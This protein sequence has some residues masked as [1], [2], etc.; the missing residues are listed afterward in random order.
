MNVIFIRHADLKYP[1][2]NYDKLSLSNLDFLA[3]EKIQPHIN[4]RLAKSKIK[5]HLADGFLTKD[6]VDAIYFSSALRAKETAALLADALNVKE[7]KELKYLKEIA[8]SP[9]ELVSNTEFKRKGMDAIRKAVYKAVEQGTADETTSAMVARIQRIQRLITNNSGRTIVIVTHG[10]FMRL[11]QIAL[12]RNQLT[13]SVSDQKR[14][15]NYDYLQGFAYTQGE[16][17]D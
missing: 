5:K 13:F 1:Y 10:F 9:K 4:R 2:N 14:A 15:V 3:T 6:G 17:N 12:L 11:L 16:N 8:F 7:T